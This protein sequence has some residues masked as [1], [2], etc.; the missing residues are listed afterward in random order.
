MKTFEDRLLMELKNVVAARVPAE[1]E[2]R[3]ARQP[4]FRRRWGMAGV[5]VL[6]A[7]GVAVGLPI[8]LGENGTKANAVEREPDGSIRIYVRDF[9]H[10]EVIERKLRDFGVKSNVT[11]LPEGKNCKE[12][13]AALMR[14]DDPRRS[15]LLQWADNAPT[16]AD[17][18]LRLAAKAIK[19]DETFVFTLWYAEQGETAASTSVGDL[20]T[21]PVRPCQVVS[22]GP[23]FTRG[24]EG[25]GGVTAGDPTPSPRAT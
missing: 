22:G 18:Y 8:A 12:P 20:A 1:G 16:G 21:G 10:P 23:G 19:P 3:P 11:F 4:T 2:R 17:Q 24:P 15:Y 14:D 25:V 9:R 5:A 6:A 7:A 13:R